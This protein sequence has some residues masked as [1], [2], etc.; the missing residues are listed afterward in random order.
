MNRGD[1]LTELRPETQAP[2]FFSEGKVQ[3]QTILH[4]MLKPDTHLARICVL[5]ALERYFFMDGIKWRAGVVVDQTGL[6]MSMPKLIDSTVP[7]LVAPMSEYIAHYNCQAYHGKT[8]YHSLGKQNI[9][10]GLPQ[11]FLT[12]YPG[13]ASQNP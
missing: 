10:P 1:L 5:N 9:P 11:M 13:F 7:C 4:H 8:I 6:A 2:K 12:V 3:T